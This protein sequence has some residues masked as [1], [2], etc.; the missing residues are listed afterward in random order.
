LTSSTD[1][2]VE[3]R[4]RA[5]RR[6]VVRVA[7][8]NRWPEELLVPRPV[9]PVVVAPALLVLDDLALVVEVLLAERVEQRPHP[10]R[11]EDIA[12]SSWCDGSVS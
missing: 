5:D 2:G 8:G 4:H 12:S 9:G 3:V 10:V 6:V 7:L 11:L 1:G